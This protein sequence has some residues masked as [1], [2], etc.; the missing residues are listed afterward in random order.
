MLRAA[1]AMLPA[2][3]PGWSSLT[4]FHA[5]GID[6]RNATILSG[7]LTIRGLF[8]HPCSHAFLTLGRNPHQGSMYD[9]FPDLPTLYDSV[10]V[11]AT[12][13][14]VQFYIDEAGDAGGSVL[15]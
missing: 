10:P 7:I 4:C 5:A 2:I 9:A 14:D 12:R 1:T 6:R 3:F 8:S 13:S 11:Y 15:E